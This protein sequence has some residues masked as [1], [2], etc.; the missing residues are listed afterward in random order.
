MLHTATVFKQNVMLTCCYTRYYDEHA[1][2][3][4]SFIELVTRAL[5]RGWNVQVWAWRGSL[6]ARYESLRATN[7]GNFEIHY[8]DL[9]RDELVYHTSLVTPHTSSIISII[10]TGSTSPNRTR[11]QQ[12]CKFYKGTAG[13]CSKGDRCTHSHSAAVAAVNIASSAPRAPGAVRPPCTYFA[14][15]AC[16]RGANCTF[17]HGITRTA[18]ATV[19][20]S[21]TA[22]VSV[23]PPAARPLPRAYRTIPCRLWNGGAGYCR[24]GSECNFLHGTVV[25]DDEQTAAATTTVEPPREYMCPI[26]AELMVDPVLSTLGYTYERAA[27]EVWLNQRGTEPYSRQPM[28]SAQLV[29]NRVA[30]DLIEK[31]RAEHPEWNADV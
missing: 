14:V 4:A 19:T 28:S 7:M 22:A 9:Y 17:S 2:M 5:S 21:A 27:I 6:S 25:V 26:S 18:S 12:P 8:L 23:S 15:G 10:S 30:K 31:W 24:W 11:P 16:N 20:T 1:H 3:Q 29:P 13:S